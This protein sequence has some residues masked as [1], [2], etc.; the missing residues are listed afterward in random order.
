MNQF[1][2]FLDQS[3][4]YGFDDKSARELRTF[5]KGALKVTPRNELDLLPEDEESKVSCTLSKT[6]SGVDPPADVKCFKAGTNN[7]SL[8][9]I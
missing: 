5:E 3:N 6:V 8:T 9:S 1:T 2:H 7:E 4:V